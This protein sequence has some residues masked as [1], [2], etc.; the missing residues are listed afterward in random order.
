M[1]V[2]AFD[3]AVPVPAFAPRTVGTVGGLIGA[4]ARPNGQKPIEQV[5]PTEVR[6]R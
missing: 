3:V 5:S 1:K 6:W 4:F 2:D